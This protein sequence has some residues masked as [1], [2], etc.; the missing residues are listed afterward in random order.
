MNRDDDSAAL[1]HQMELEARR[2]LEDELLGNDPDYIKW[3]DQLNEDNERGHDQ[4]RRQRIEVSE[5]R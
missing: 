1:A 4:V 3:L 2:R 5:S